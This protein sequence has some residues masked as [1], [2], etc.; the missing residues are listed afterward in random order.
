MARSQQPFNSASRQ[1]ACLLQQGRL[2]PV[3]WGAM[4]KPLIN[5]VRQCLAVQ[6]RDRPSPI[7]LLEHCVFSDSERTAMGTTAEGTCIAGVAS[8]SVG[9]YPAVTRLASC[10]H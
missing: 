9:S 7:E 10:G 6:M 4:S 1:N 8:S 5:L 2:P 3:D